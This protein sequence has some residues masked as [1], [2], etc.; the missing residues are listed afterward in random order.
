MADAIGAEALVCI[1]GRLRVISSDGSQR[2]PTGQRER[3]LLL[4]LALHGGC[5]HTEQAV[6]ALWP[7]QPPHLGRTRL[8][9][10]LFRLREACG[11]IVRREGACLVLVAETDIGRYQQALATLLQHVG[12]ELAPDVRYTD[13]AE[14]VRRQLTVVN[15]RLIALLL[16]PE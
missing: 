4:F 10:V 14:D 13:W 2:V 11:P 15:D 7:D 8:R 3:C 16:D 12:Q 6:E 9:M 5:V 1:L